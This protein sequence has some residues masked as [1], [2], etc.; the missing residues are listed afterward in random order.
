MKVRPFWGEIIPAFLIFH[1]AVGESDAWVAAYS[2]EREAWW[3]WLSCAQALG[4]PPLLTKW[5]D[6]AANRKGLGQLDNL[7]LQQLMYH[8]IQKP[9]WDL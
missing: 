2:P 4:S 8:V 3:P 7:F 5:P 1:L 6:I 9:V